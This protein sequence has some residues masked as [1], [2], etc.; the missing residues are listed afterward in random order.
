[1]ETEVK[2]NEV[3]K[4][5]TPTPTSPKL[6]LIVFG[7]MINLG[8]TAHQYLMFLKAYASPTKSIKLYIDVFHEADTELVLLTISMI[9]GIIATVYVLYC[10]RAGKRII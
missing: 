7:L 9:L 6:L 2:V 3:N 1:M 8:L 10:I 4:K 5:A